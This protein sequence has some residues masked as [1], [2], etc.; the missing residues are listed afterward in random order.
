MVAIGQN[1]PGNAFASNGVD[2][3]LRRL[4]GINTNITVRVENKMTIKVIAV[5]FRKPRPGQ[6]SAD[7]LSH[8]P[9]RYAIATV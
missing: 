6:N 1:N 7:D 9:L 3:A 5:R 8:V 4:D 2:V